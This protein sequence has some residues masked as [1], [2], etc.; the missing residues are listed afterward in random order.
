[1]IFKYHLSH[2]DLTLFRS[3]DFTEKARDSAREARKKRWWCFFLLL[4]ILA[5]VAIVVGVVVSQNIH[6]NS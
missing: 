6:H 1:V 3:K 2:Q 4:V 5:I